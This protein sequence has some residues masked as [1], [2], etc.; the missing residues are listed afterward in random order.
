MPKPAPAKPASV[1]NRASVAAAP[2]PVAAGESPAR[3]GARH[4]PLNQ[5]VA[6][7]LRERIL[8][9]EFAPGERLAEER[10]S[11][12]MG[13]S[14][15]PVREALRA[16]AAE[17]VVTVNPRRGAQVTAYTSTQAHELIEVRAALEA[18]NAKLAAKRRDPALIAE[19]RRIMAE[20][21]GIDERTDL[22]RIQAANTRFHEALARL[23]ANAVLAT[24]VRS[25]RDRTAIIFAG[26]S[27][28]RVRQNWDDHAAILRAVVAGDEELAGLLASRHVYNAAAPL[29]AEGAAAPAK[30]RPRATS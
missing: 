20:S 29:D 8:S 23:G 19:L 6:D 7:T 30:R 14:R 16:L 11:E 24:I 27:R 17:G 25:L 28:V 13:I 18:L 2:A 3:L 10:L 26:Q 1:R 5:M 9:G 4:V 22:A 21:A 12:E 15:M